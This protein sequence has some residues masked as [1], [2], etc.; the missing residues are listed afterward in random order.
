MARKTLEDECFEKLQ[1]LLITLRLPPGKL[2]TEAELMDFSGFTRSPVRGAVSR[3]AKTGLLQTLPQ[4]GILVTP[5]SLD[6][7]LNISEF[8]IVV[9]TWCA[10]TAVERISDS[11]ISELEELFD[12]AAELIEAKELDRY[13]KVDLR[14]HRKLA[15]S[16]ENKYLIDSL[17][18]LFSLSVRFW[19]ISFRRAGRLKETL[20]EHMDIID[21]L[22]KRDPERAASA[23]EHHLIQSRQ[24]ILKVTWDPDAAVTAV[25]VNHLR[26]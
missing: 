15:A 13:V 9:E 16:T 10:K 25:P 4:K 11:A 1:Q 6:D 3:L 21:C 7:F 2:T 12:R 26:S 23:M 18:Q 22:K 20:Q 24:K 8:R 5:L 17:T 14:F 19:Y